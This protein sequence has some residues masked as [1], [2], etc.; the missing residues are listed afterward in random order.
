L[1]VT[2]RGMEGKS[3]GESDAA[4]GVLEAALAEH[5]ERVYLV[6]Y[7]ILGDRQEAEDL[8][9]ETFWQLHNRPP[10]QPENLGGW[11][12]RV[13]SNLGLNALR[14]RQRRQAY[15]FRAGSEALDQHPPTSPAVEAEQ[16][17]DRERVRA[18]LGTMKERDARLLVLRYSGFAYAEIAAVLD[19][20][21]GSIGNLLARAEAEFERRFRA[22]ER[23]E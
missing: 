18:V 3:A 1:E 2:I 19:V 13:A 20:S 9:L 16:R 4:N 14:S 8:A 7:R 21:P 10:K 11:L 12:Y 22:Q 5:W 23:E 15:E 17:M 6:L